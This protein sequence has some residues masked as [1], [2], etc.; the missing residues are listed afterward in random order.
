MENILGLMNSEPIQI[1][2]EAYDV[3]LDVSFPRGMYVH[4][5][6]IYVAIYVRIYYVCNEYSIYIYMYLLSF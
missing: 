3:A 6:C 5:Y 1:H 2:A 4:T